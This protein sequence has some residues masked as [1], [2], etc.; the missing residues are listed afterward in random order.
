[1][2]GVPMGCSMARRQADRQLAKYDRKAVGVLSTAQ[3]HTHFLD[4]PRMA[5]VLTDRCRRVALLRRPGVRADSIRAEPPSRLNAL[6]MCQR[7]DHSRN[8]K[9]VSISIPTMTRRIVCIRKRRLIQALAVR[10]G[11]LRL[12]GSD[13]RLPFRTGMVFPH[14]GFRPFP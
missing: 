9:K 12:L 1:M 8:A 10:I 2:T 4:S 7:L 14:R 5:T 11:S 6:V 13:R 3:R